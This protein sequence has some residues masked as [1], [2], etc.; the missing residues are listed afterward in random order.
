MIEIVSESRCVG[1][2]LCVKVCPM[3]VFDAREDGVPVIA[4]LGDC[5][6]CFVCEAYC[7][8]DALYVSPLA[9]ELEHA[10]EQALDERG[11]LGSWRAQIG[12]GVGRRPNMAERDTSHILNTIRPVRNRG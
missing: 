11:A 12:W 3:N 9:D 2:G 8:A 1:C 4:R 5:Q 6:T 7:P 10:D